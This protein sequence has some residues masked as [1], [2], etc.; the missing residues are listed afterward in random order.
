MPAKETFAN[1]ATFRLT[2]KSAPRA[3]LVM[4]ALLCLM[5]VFT[6]STV[7]VQQAWALQCFQIGIYLLGA[8]YR[9]KLRSGRP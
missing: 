1:A 3:T 8:V 9:V 2:D 7:F 5:L 4:G 6:T